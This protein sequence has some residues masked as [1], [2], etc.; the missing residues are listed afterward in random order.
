MGGV[1][2]GWQDRDVWEVWENI[3]NS[4]NRRMHFVQ[5]EVGGRV[6]SIGTFGRFGRFGKIFVNREIEGSERLQ[7]LCF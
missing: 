4:G 1:R 7:K 3:C 6:G 5:K 2:E